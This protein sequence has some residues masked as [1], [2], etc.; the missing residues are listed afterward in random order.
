MAER[1]F[2][3]FRR[4]LEKSPL[5]KGGFL[6]VS[7]PYLRGGLRRGLFSIICARSVDH[8]HVVGPEQVRRD[9][10]KTHPCDAPTEVVWPKFRAWLAEMMLCFVPPNA[11]GRWPSSGELAGSRTATHSPRR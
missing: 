2:S 4:V 5:L 10:F 9:G 8:A 6:C 3:F 7:F 11:R 1:S